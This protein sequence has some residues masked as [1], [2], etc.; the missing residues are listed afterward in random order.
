MFSSGGG[1]DHHAVHFHRLPQVERQLHVCPVKLE[2][3]D[4]TGRRFWQNKVA[5]MRG[6]E[7]VEALLQPEQPCQ[8]QPVVLATQVGI[9]V[10]PPLLQ[11]VDVFFVRHR[12]NYSPEPTPARL[13]DSG[14]I[15]RQQPTPLN[16]TVPRARNS[17]EF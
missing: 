2:R 9:H 5:I 11:A 3:P 4:E 14:Q 8:R 15:G 1:L 16:G 17:S 6:S 10:F 12:H 7:S 13:A